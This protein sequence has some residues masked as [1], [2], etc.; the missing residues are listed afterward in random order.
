MLQKKLRTE[1]LD[2]PLSKSHL[3]YQFE[4]DSD[5]KVIR[6]L[7]GPRS[8]GNCEGEDRQEKGS[9]EESEGGAKEWV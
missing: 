1:R 7:H 5:P 8:K 6:F 2:L 9:R 4:L 3:E